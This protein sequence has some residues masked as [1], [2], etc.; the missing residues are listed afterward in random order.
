MPSPRRVRLLVLAAVVLTVFFFFYSS[1]LEGKQ[2]H[3]LQDFYHKTM[4]A[5]DG[6]GKA[7]GQAILDTQTGAK[8]GQIP[9]DRDG[10]GDIDADDQ[11][12]A[13]EIQE[14]L[15]AAEQKAKVNANEKG[16]L[17]PDLPS[18]VVGVGS[19]AEGQKKTDG[20]SV[21][22]GSDADA[23]LAREELAVETEL[24]AILK[25]SPGKESC[26]SCPP[27]A[28]AR[29]A[30]ND[31]FSVIIFSK[32]YCP[33]SKRAKGLLL[34]KYSI[35]PDPYVVELDEHELGPA[36]QDH[37]LKKTG[38]RTVPNVLINGVSIGGADDIVALDNLDKLVDK[39]VELGS[40]RVNM[41]ERF[42]SS[43]P[44]A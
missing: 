8:A 39:I 38:R 27:T 28:I 24:N 22:A 10:D 44:Q 9:A 4:N 33:Y 35:T 16:G 7:P 34:E 42:V 36:L 14:R 17:R 3:N 26:H 41:V 2:Q 1:G 25:K 37:L 5:M 12:S 18:K 40:P 32:S 29:A 30:A 21:A 15:K 43:G 11:K 20:D 13:V 23:P 6:A 31:R 19:S